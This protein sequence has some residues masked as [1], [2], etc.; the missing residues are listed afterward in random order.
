MCVLLIKD[1]TTT[2]IIKGIA[3]DYEMLIKSRSTFHLNP[4]PMVNV[5]SFL[6]SPK[7]GV[8]GRLG[9]LS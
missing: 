3:Q 2:Q 4:L 9:R 1:K 6:D 5:S 8:L 7:P